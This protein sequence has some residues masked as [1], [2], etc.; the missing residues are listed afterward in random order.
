MT[1]DEDRA[2]AFWEW[3]YAIS[4]YQIDRPHEAVTVPKLVALLADVRGEG[5][6]EGRGRLEERSAQCSRLRAA[7]LRDPVDGT[8]RMCGGAPTDENKLCGPCF[9]DLKNNA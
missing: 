7:L 5:W 3:F 6:L 2:R 1:T 8:C 4:P 9:D